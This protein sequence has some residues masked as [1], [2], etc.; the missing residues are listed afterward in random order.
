VLTLLGP[1]VALDGHEDVALCGAHP[2]AIA[3]LA[4]PD[5]PMAAAGPI[6]VMVGH[7]NFAH[8]WSNVLPALTAVAGTGPHAG[9]PW[10]DDDRLVDADGAATYTAQALARHLPG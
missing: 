1:A 9:H 8:H 10:N 2:R 6:P 5:A 4:Q 7:P 3:G